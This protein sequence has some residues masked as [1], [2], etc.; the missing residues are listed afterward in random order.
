MSAYKPPEGQ[1]VNFSFVENDYV[2]PKGNSVLFDF[3]LAPI[4][5]D[6]VSFYQGSEVLATPL[7]GIWS[8]I[9]GNQ[10]EFKF[11]SPHKTVSGNNLDL[12][13]HCPVVILDCQEKWHDFAGDQID[14]DFDARFISGLE[15]DQIDF[16]FKCETGGPSEDVILGYISGFD[17]ASS[18]SNLQE[19]FILNAFDGSTFIPNVEF[20]N[21]YLD[22]TYYE[23]AWVN[24]NLSASPQLYPL[25]RDGAALAAILTPATYTTLPFNLFDGSVVVI[26]IATKITFDFDFG[27]GSTLVTDLYT[28]PP[29]NPAA[30]V[31]D[32]AVGIASIQISRNFAPTA[33]DGAVGTFDLDYVHNEGMPAD[34]FDGAEGI[35]NLQIEPGFEPTALEGAEAIA[36]LAAAYGLG[37]QSYQGTEVTFDLTLR[38]NIQFVPAFF[39]GAEGNLNL[40]TST[41]FEFEVDD[42]SVFVA[43]FTPRAPV[44]LAPNALDGAALA[45]FL[46]AGSISLHFFGYEGAAFTA[47]FT[48]A[49]QPAIALQAADGARGDVTISFAQN[50]GN[51]NFLEGGRG[52]ILVLD[53]NP[54]IFAYEGTSLEAELATE[55]TVPNEYSDGAVAVLDLNIRPSEGMGLFRTW[56]GEELQFG[57]LATLRS[58]TFSVLFRNS[59]VTQADI[60][61]GTG[62]DLTTDACCGPRDNTGHV[63]MS[64]AEAPDWHYYGYKQIFTVDL[65]CRPRFSA[66]MFEGSTLTSK[67]YSKYF[68]FDFA[69]GA[70]SNLVAFDQDILVR[71]CK[72][73]FIPDGDNVV[74]ELISTDTEDCEVN[75]GYEGAEMFCVLE[76]NVQDTLLTFEGAHMDAILTVP[77]NWYF[78]FWDGAHLSIHNFPAEMQVNM[79]DGAAATFRFAE[80]LWSGFEGAQFTIGSLTT[81]YDVEFLEVGCLDNEFIPTNENGDPEPELAHTVPMEFD[82]F[83]HELKARCY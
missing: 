81:E 61:S 55:T 24:L 72:G 9:Q 35:A 69:D 19:T 82:P 30:N 31:A 67:D 74:V 65:S 70:Q 62:F 16:D 47:D 40:A 32:G 3:T 73:N 29:T 26:D 6:V 63:E 51:F 27:D 8:P 2:A 39:E 53:E 54:L 7:C 80:Q 42:G 34:A 12:A 13:W 1:R 49:P 77:T 56:V 59:W 48:P 43:D 23:G 25:A 10:I 4:L 46:N 78:N 44:L 58:A 33:L 21:I 79:R 11:K 41:T 45:S 60:D 28:R 71:L 66:N 5:L 22:Q 75:F 57:A 36:S 76:N 83:Y 64:F 50:L 52:T 38:P 37:V 68:N 18:N 20:I 14:L 17:G 15:G